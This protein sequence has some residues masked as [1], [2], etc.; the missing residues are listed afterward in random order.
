[1]DWWVGGWVDE[2]KGM[3]EVIQ[4]AVECVSC[5]LSI[6]WTNCFRAYL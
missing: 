5:C 6:S 3:K 1:M 2:C 4:T